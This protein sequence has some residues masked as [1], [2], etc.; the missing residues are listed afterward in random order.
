MEIRRPDRQQPGERLDGMLD[1][2]FHVGKEIV[3]IKLTAAAIEAVAILPQKTDVVLVEAFQRLPVVHRNDA[4][5][6]DGIDPVEEKDVP[7]DLKIIRI[8]R[9]PNLQREC[10]PMSQS[11][12]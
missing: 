11:I 10:L 7:A 6:D 3:L 1:A 12:R 5:L 8:H 2:R 4:F 9:A